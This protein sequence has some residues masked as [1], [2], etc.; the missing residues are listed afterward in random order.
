L[1]KIGAQ[2]DVSHVEGQ[3]PKEYG[4]DAVEIP[5]ARALLDAFSAAKIPWGIVT[6]GTRALMD[7]WLGRM[8]LA[9]A[10]HSVV[11]E[12][13]DAGKPDP[14]CYL[15]GKQRLGLGESDP[16][17]VIE[18]A[19]AGIKAGRAAGC[20]VLGLATTHSLEQVRGAG[21]DWVVQDLRS[22]RL[23]RSDE[24]MGLIELEISRTLVDPVD[25][26]TRDCQK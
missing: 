19:P 6:S 9:R 26:A 15:L 11:A 1:A 22:I 24:G 23:V 17:L 2:L 3:I 10:Q 12:D 14:A 8:E 7:G 13:V 5:G 16:V 20:K 21:A 25:I 18:D 4:A